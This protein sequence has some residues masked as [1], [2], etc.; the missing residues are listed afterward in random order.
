MTS[1]SDYVDDDCVTDVRHGSNAGDGEDDDP[2]ELGV[3]V[4]GVDL[5]AA[6][7]E[8]VVCGVR[9]T[10]LLA[11]AAHHRPQQTQAEADPPRMRSSCVAWCCTPRGLP[12]ATMLSMEPIGRSLNCHVAGSFL[13]PPLFAIS[14]PERVWSES[15]S[16]DGE[17]HAHGPEPPQ[18]PHIHRQ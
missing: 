15:L 16:G 8:R 11:E 4:V 13:T 10:P 6:A 5:G 14:V 1:S 9:L 17:I 7:S 18:H 2:R 12:F 3:G